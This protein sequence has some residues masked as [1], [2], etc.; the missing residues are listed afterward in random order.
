MFLPQF[1]MGNVRDQS[2]GTI[3]EESDMWSKLANPTDH[4]KGRCAE[5]PYKA[6]CGGNSRARAYAI[7]GDLWAPDPRCYLTEDER[8]IESTNAA[9]DRP[10]IARTG[11]D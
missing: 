11:G 3:L 4:L 2:L 9:D 6:V 5:C 10:S 8:R 7:H 1:T